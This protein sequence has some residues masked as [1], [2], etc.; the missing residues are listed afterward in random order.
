MDEGHE[1]RVAV[2]TGGAGGIGRATALELA[3]QGA[4]VVVADLDD[5][6]AQE[7]VAQVEALGRAASFVRTDVSSAD[8]LEALMTAC[9]QAHGRL[10]VM[11]NNAGVAS[12]APLLEWTPEQ[13]RK[14]VAVNQDGVF[15]GMQAAARAMRELGRGGVIINTGSVYGRLATRFAS[16]YQATKAAV[17][18]L[19]RVAALELA[20]LG[21]RVVNVAPG[22]VDTRMTDDYRRMGVIDA[23][24]R[25]HMGG[26]LVQPEQVARV[27]ALVASDAAAAINGTTVYADD[28]YSAFK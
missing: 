27:V 13:Y 18:V 10:D 6:G 23:M 2:V 8:E 5:A 11:F 28:G 15:F 12:G 3:R 19:T 25:K 20:P 17:E 24:A 7:T 9:V 1:G 22:V 14:V 26:A 21:I 4:A 16:A